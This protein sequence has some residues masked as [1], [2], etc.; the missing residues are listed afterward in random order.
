MLTLLC[1]VDAVSRTCGETGFGIGYTNSWIRQI[2]STNK[3]PPRPA[4]ATVPC[5]QPKVG[6]TSFVHRTAA[7]AAAK[8]PAEGWTSR[9]EKRPCGAADEEAECQK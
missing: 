1:L 3:I 5:K 4:A 2:N 8:Q 7:A 6:R 9:Q